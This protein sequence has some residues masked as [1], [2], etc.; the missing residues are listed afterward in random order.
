MRQETRQAAI[1]GCRQRGLLLMAGLAVIFMVI[2]AAAPAPVQ[3]SSQVAELMLSD[4]ADA[5]GVVAQHQSRFSP[6][7]GEIF[8]TALIAGA[9]TGKEITTK[10]FYVTQNLEVLS[11]TK[12]LTGS[13]EVTFTFAFP[14]PSKGWPPGDYRLVISTSDGATKAVTFQV[15]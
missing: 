8:G 4:R 3:A 12:D 11:V 6:S 15:K 7:V 5:N 9:G 10:L 13:G 2:M 1:T 14:K